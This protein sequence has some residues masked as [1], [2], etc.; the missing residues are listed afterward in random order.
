MTT[1]ITWRPLRGVPEFEMALNAEGG[2]IGHVNYVATRWVACYMGQRTLHL[3]QVDAKAWVEQQVGQPVV[4]V[5]LPPDPISLRPIWLGALIVAAIFLV[6]LF[7]G[8]AATPQEPLPHYPC[9]DKKT[10]KHYE[11]SDQEWLIRRKT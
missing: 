9:W 2:E 5:T 3:N 7:T 6:V 4:A 1:Q 8:C 10:Q 11:C